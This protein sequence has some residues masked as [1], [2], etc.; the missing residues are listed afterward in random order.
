MQLALIMKSRVIFEQ[1]DLV[2]NMILNSLTLPLSKDALLKSSKKFGYG[3][4]LDGVLHIVDNIGSEVK[5]AAFRSSGGRI[6][7]GGRGN[8][9]YYP[10]IIPGKG[11]V[12]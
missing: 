5:K 12:S 1:Y 11:K 2:E 9:V 6:R 3:E 4:E 7:I 8:R 10:I